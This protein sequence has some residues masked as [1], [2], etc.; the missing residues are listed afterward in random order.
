MRTYLGTFVIAAE[1]FAMFLNGR[2]SLSSESGTGK[3]GIGRRRISHVE[4]TEQ[5]TG[6]EVQQMTNA[7]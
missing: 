1:I 2:A 4:A 5:L 3:N 7:A 6:R